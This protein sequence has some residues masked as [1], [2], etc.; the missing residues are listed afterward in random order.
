MFCCAYLVHEPDGGALEWVLL[1][2]VDAHLPDTA[3]VRRPGGA[4]ELHYEL[5]QAAEDIHLVLG[6]DELDDVGVHAA[7]ARGAKLSG[8]CHIF[9]LE[10]NL[11]LQI[12]SRTQN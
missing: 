6:L 1:G 8:T 11:P 5:V 2:E 10:A 7:L 12:R 4:E 3:L 9:L